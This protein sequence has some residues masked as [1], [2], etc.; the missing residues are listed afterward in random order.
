MAAVL[1]RFR[2]FFSFPPMPAEAPAPAPA[3]PAAS[4]DQFFGPGLAVEIPKIPRE[5]KKLWQDNQGV[6]T[7]ASR[8]NLV[9]YSA[10]ERS[11]RENT[12][13]VEG[14]AREHALRAVVVAAKAHRTDLGDRPR[15]WINAHCQ[16]SKAGAKQRCSEQIAF[17]LPG[18]T[19]GNVP[20]TESLIFSH[21]DSDLPLYLWW[22]GDLPADPP[23]DLMTWVDRFLVHSGEWTRSR[24]GFA[25]LCGHTAFRRLHTNLGDL[26]WT[27]LNELRTAL[28]SFF[29]APDTGPAD[30]AALNRVEIE[31]AAGGR[32]R[33]LF[34][35]GWLAVRLGWTLP[36]GNGGADDPLGSGDFTVALDNGRGGRVSAT[37]RGGADANGARVALG[38]NA[39][40]EFT[41]T[42]TAGSPFYNTSARR[43]PGDPARAQVLPAGPDDVAE[44]VSAELLHNGHHRAYLRVLEF[45]GPIL[46]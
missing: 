34:L 24:E 18:A 41:V 14:V 9:I 15:A 42:R 17:E 36:A 11:L 29:D 38:T 21:L 46:G 30:L 43:R 27:R 19:A 7:R 32:L 33:A 16:I 3:S 2:Y 44:L 45:I 28:A 13:I 10:A 6:A 4:G 22:R 25:L 5:L 8:L 26:N 23:G 12:A 1:K 31:H 40:A 39:G 35:L 37:L 20:L